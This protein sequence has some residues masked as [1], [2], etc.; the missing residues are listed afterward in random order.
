MYRR[1]GD[2]VTPYA[3]RL[4]KSSKGWKDGKPFG[5]NVRVE[6]G[7]KI[8]W[9]ELYAFHTDWVGERIA[10]VKQAIKSERARRS[11]SKAQQREPAGAPVVETASAA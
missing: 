3:A 9:V 1:E 7:S 6:L 8:Q 5:I 4:V 11:A 10:A 2:V